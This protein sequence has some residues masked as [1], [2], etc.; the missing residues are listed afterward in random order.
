MQQQRNFTSITLSERSQTQKSTHGVT[1]SKHSTKWTT[2]VLL[3]IRIVQ[4]WGDSAWSRAWAVR[5]VLCLDLSAGCMCM[6]TFIE[7]HT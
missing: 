4:T 2:F 6:L 1:Q 5:N 3:E 7:L